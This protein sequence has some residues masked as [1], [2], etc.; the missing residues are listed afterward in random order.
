MHTRKSVTSIVNYS[1]PKK[2]ESSIVR[3]TLVYL[4]KG[5]VSWAS[6]PR[7]P[8]SVHIHSSRKG[9]EFTFAA[10][11]LLTMEIQVLMYR[12]KQEQL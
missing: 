5:S 9:P 8:R 7:G 11:Y 6:S 4:K 10:G 2:D 12:A 3:A 1:D